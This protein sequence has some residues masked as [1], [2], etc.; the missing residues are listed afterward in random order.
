MAEK[1][2]KAAIITRTKDRP[3]FLERALQSI[4]GQSFSNFKLVIVNEGGNP[5]AFGKAVAKFKKTKPSINIATIHNKIS[6]G[7]QNALNKAINSTDSKYIAIHDDDDSWHPDFLKETVNYLEK[8][9]EMG[10]WVKTQKVIE[11]I[12]KDKIK[13]LSKSPWRPEIS[14]MDLFKVC[15][16]NFAPPISM[17]YSREA[18]KTIGKYDETF[19]TAGDWDFMIRFLTQY[20]IDF[21]DP[22]H[23]LAYY[24]LRPDEKGDQVNSVL[25][26]DQSKRITH[27]KN[28]Y[29]RRDLNQGR[30]G[31]GYIVNSLGLD[32]E[33]KNKIDNLEKRID[34]LEN[35][36]AELKTVI[37]DRTSIV[38]IVK[39]S[40]K[41]AIKLPK[42]FIK[43]KQG[44]N[45]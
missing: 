24:H 34:E 4:Y 40:G 37:N 15:Q 31:I 6:I 9:G 43:N 39:R 45:D 22:G 26:S 2:P 42:Q 18:V 13:I 27:L 14:D 30:L 44:K 35:K 3:L 29:L 36:L 11:K 16:Q 7:S 32:E 5:Q 25:S 19:G 10:V 33:Q 8:T 28:E 20:N 17:L 21:L 38:N 41:G 1:I 12:E 23:P